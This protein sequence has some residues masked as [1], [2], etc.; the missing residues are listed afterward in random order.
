VSTAAAEQ[1]ARP[2]GIPSIALNLM[3]T[4]T[5][6]GLIL[7][8][9]NFF[10]QPIRERNEAEFKEMARAAVLPQASRFDPIEG[11]AAGHEWFKGFDQQGELVGYVVPVKNRGYEGHIEMMLGVDASLAITEFKLIKHRETPGLGA[12]AVEQEFHDRFKGR[13]ADQLEVSKRAEGGKILAITGAT[14]TSKAIAD[15]FNERLAQL[16]ILASADFQDIPSELANPK[17]HR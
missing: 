5:L 1:G 10:T 8:T 7:A 4:A 15:A 14:I 9:L 3:W 2:A 11:F 13:K 12:K 17:E 6:S 16:D